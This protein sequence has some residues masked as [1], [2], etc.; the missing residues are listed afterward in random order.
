MSSNDH[1][2][3]AANSWGSGY[4]KIRR[5]GIVEI[6][7]DPRALVIIGSPDLKVGVVRDRMYTVI[8]LHVPSGRGGEGGSR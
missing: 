3:G 8:K 4:G 2:S 1:D 7:R 6:P 5:T